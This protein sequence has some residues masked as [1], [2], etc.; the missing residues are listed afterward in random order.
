MRHAFVMS[1]ICC[2]MWLFSCLLSLCCHWAQLICTCKCMHA[3]VCANI[4][5]YVDGRVCFYEMLSVGGCVHG[6]S[7]SALAWV[8]VWTGVWAWVLVCSRCI[9]WHM[10]SPLGWDADPRKR[11]SM[12]VIIKEIRAGCR[13]LSPRFDFKNVANTNDIVVANKEPVYISNW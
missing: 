10:S 6:V 4:F 2:C 5:F 13:Q 7:F 3:C 12:S 8:R 9:Y 11:P 1:I